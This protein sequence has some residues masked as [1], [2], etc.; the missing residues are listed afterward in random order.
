MKLVLVQ[1]YAC[2]FYSRILEKKG[3]ISKYVHELGKEE[4]WDKEPFMRKRKTQQ[5][6]QGVQLRYCEFGRG[7]W[8]HLVTTKAW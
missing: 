8:L 4:T 7:W 5:E 1:K 2:R 6:T 3:H